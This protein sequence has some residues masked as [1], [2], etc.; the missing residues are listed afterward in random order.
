MKS[1]ALAILFACV[2]AVGVVVGTLVPYEH[3]FGRSYSLVQFS[4]FKYTWGGLFSPV[5]IASLSVL[6]TTLWGKRHLLGR[7]A[8]V[9][10][11][12]VVTA[13]DAAGLVADLATTTASGLRAG[14]FILFL[15]GVALI[16]AGVALMTVAPEVS[17][18]SADHAPRVAAPPAGWFP[19]PANGAALLRY[20][21]G[22]QWTDQTA[23]V[24]RS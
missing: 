6:A 17:T 16:G 11:M 15:G 2:G 7:G 10:G 8:L 9:V 1:R 5:V 20:W 22:A 4:Q 18:E 21:D 12:G 19:D 13:L 23:P 24:Q 14:G 3:Q